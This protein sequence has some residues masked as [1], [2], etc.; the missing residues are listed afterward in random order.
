MSRKSPGPGD[1]VERI[2]LVAATFAVL[3]FGFGGDYERPDPAHFIALAAGAAG[4][5]GVLAQRRWAGGLILFSV[6][7]VG[8]FGRA[9]TGDNRASDVMLTTN[10]ALTVLASGNNPYTHAYA[11][12]NPPGGLLGYPPGELAFYGFAHLLGAN[13]FRVDVLAGIIVLGLIAC[14]A[15]LVG[16]GL[17]ALAIAALADDRDIIFHAADGSNDT[18]ASML[19]LSAVVTL[20]WSLATRGRTSRA[21]WW[22]SAVAFGWVIA[23]KE[24]ALPIVVFVALF[25]WRAD[26][27]RARA[28]IAVAAGSVALFVLPFLA[29]NPVAFVSNVG[30][31]LVVHDTVWGRNVWH[32][33]LSYVPGA[34]GAIAPLIPAITLLAFAGAAVALW[35]RPA[36]SLGV[37]LLYGCALLATVF[38][39]ARWTTSVYY[40]FLAPLV[41][42]GIALT[43]GAGDRGGGTHACTVSARPSSA[44]NAA[45]SAAPKRRLKRCCTSRQRG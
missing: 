1:P 20:A 32:D 14:L 10:E 44:V 42:A 40:V 25:L 37:A 15:P 18:A 26:A 21:L 7:A 33:V 8:A 43:L 13:V 29:W 4:L 45:E 39:L 22:T 34:T 41:A 35:R 23:F 11:M 9:T 38:V 12:T 30:G 17:A 2:A 36:P 24:Y 3:I 16:D 31:A 6:W 19:A 27:Q 28:W 5:A